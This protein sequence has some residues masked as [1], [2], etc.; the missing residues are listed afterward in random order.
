MI[1]NVS[2]AFI[3]YLGASLS[4]SKNFSRAIFIFLRLSSAIV[5]MLELLGLPF[6]GL[7]LTKYVFSGS[8]ISPA[9]IFTY[10]CP[11]TSASCTTKNTAFAANN[12]FSRSIS[13]AANALAW[14]RHADSEGQCL[15]KSE[16]KSFLILACW[17]L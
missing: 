14:L 17:S 4:S 13:L 12:S 11:D 8:S 2:S 15:S 6:N 9:K 5:Q 7:Q 10:F 3:I 16:L 1:F